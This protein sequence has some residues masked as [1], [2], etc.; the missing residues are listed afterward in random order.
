[1]ARIVNGISPAYVLPSITSGRVPGGNRCATSSGRTGQWTNVRSAQN[2]S[3][4]HGRRKRRRGDGRA[5]PTTSPPHRD[6][7][8]V[9]SSPTSWS[10]GRYDAIGDHIAAI[11]ADVVSAVGGRLPLRGAAVAD[12]ACGTGSAA[13]AASAAGARVTGVDIT[14]EL[15][16]LGRAEGRGAGVAVNWRDGGRLRHRT[17]RRVVRRRGVEHGHHL[18]RAHH[19]RSPR[20]RGCSG[21]AVCWASPRG[22]PIGTSRSSSRS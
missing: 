7:L 19:A 9:M 2:C 14:P 20:S 16:A 13:L 17:A 15:I 3:N 12:L 21:R 5:R 4:A 11:A 6:T 22:C 18:R 8:G 1:M 10:S